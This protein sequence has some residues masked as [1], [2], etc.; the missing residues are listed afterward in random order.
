MHI[1][2]YFHIFKQKAKTCFP[3]Q[4]P[5]CL[6]EFH[7]KLLIHSVLG[8]MEL[9]AMKYFPFFGGIF[10]AHDPECAGSKWKGYE[11]YVTI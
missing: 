7:A 2:I 4:N 3:K 8:N 1:Y 11:E 9:M 6:R 10:T 5:Y